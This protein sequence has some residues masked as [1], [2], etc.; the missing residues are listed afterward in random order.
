MSW[1]AHKVYKYKSLIHNLMKIKYKDLVKTYCKQ[2][3]QSILYP[4]VLQ[5]YKLGWSVKRISTHLKIPLSSVYFWANKKTTP[6]PYNVYKSIK[7]QFNK[8][9]ID[10]LAIVM[11]HIF[12]DGGIL[13]NG[14]IHY[15]NTEKFLINEFISSMKKI[16]SEK[17]SIIYEKNKFKNIIKI[18][19]P[20]KIGRILW[21]L[22]GKF[23]YGLDTKNITKGIKNQSL[24]WHTNMLQAWFNDDGSVP[25]TKIVSIKQKPKNLIL[26][27]Q[28]ILKKHNI[29]S[30]ITK[31]DSRWLLRILRYTE[32]VKF[33]EKINFSKGYRKRKQLDEAIKKIKIPMYKT[34]NQILDILKKSPKTIKKLSNYFNIQEKSIYGHL[35]GYKRSK[36]SGRKSNPGL[37]EIGLVKTQGLPRNRFYLIKVY[38]IKL[39][40]NKLKIQ[41]PKGL[42]NH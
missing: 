25:Q 16:F 2:Y 1:G 36:I 33:K 20:A 30:H 31:D 38:Y 12:G 32:L 41:D 15:C 42:F 35:H 40:I 27:I 24:R 5:L 29:T 37:I 11:G 10:N 34:K 26:F 22:F 39:S 19:Y 23:S 14:V 9:D 21:C 4:K 8:Q 28:E 3:Q 13:K 7:K 6:V 18:R 17:P